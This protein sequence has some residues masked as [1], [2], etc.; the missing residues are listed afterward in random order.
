MLPA[1]AGIFVQRWCPRKKWKPW[2]PRNPVISRIRQRQR[3]VEACIS[4]L[5]QH[6][7]S[8]TT[9]DKV[10]AIADMSPGIVNFYFDTKAAL[11]VAALEFLAE[12]FEDRVLAPLAAMKNDPVR[13]LEHLIVLYLDP[14]IASPRKVSVWYAFWGEASSR[15]EYYAICGK[16]DEAFADLVRNLV[17]RLIRQDGR[18][19]VDADGVALG[20]IGALEMIWQDIAFHD[21]ADLDRHGAQQRCIAYLRS[22]FPAQFGKGYPQSAIST[23]SASVARNEASLPTAEKRDFARLKNS[24]AMLVVAELALAGVPAVEAPGMSTEYNILAQPIDGLPQR[25]AVA[26]DKDW[27]GVALSNASD[28][29]SFDWLAIVLVPQEESGIRRISVVPREAVGDARGLGAGVLQELFCAYEN[30]FGLSRAR[31]TL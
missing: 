5:Y 30:N 6:G 8:R 18:A 19:H 20:L 3:L 1:Q 31:L 2:A 25:I 28:A 26:V 29:T 11:L 23:A 17:E 14:E 12:E 16:R 10:V 4:A 15:S 22:V 7:P 9:I 24:F 21:E 13:A 27:S